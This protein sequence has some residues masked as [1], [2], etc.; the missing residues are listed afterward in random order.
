MWVGGGLDSA[1]A[2]S[3]KVFKDRC[4]WCA[5]LLGKDKGNSSCPFHSQNQ[6]YQMEVCFLG[7]P[8]LRGQQDNKGLVGRFVSLGGPGRQAGGSF[9]RTLCHSS[10][11][12]WYSQPNV[13]DLVSALVTVTFFTLSLPS[14]LKPILGFLPKAAA[15]TKRCT[16]SLSS[17]QRE[18]VD[19]AV[20]AAP[21]ARGLC[22]PGRGRTLFSMFIHIVRVTAVFQRV[23]FCGCQCSQVRELHYLTHSPL[24]L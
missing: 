23:S 18:V 4:R 22:Y 9:T 3:S 20:S 24:Q 16:H 6:Q 8:V 10:L 2:D 5:V 12:E 21:F 17:G 14:Q 7:I 19:A 15:A 11:Q 13:P 1:G